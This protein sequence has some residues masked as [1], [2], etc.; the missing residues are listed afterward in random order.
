[1]N[2]NFGICVSSIFFICSFV[3]VI[4]SNSDIALKKEKKFVPSVCQISSRLV[5]GACSHLGQL[6]QLPATKNLFQ[7]TNINKTLIKYLR[8]Q[9]SGQKKYHLQA[10]LRHF[11][12]ELVLLDLWKG[13]ICHQPKISI[14]CDRE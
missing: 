14:F 12:R 2:F 5:Y 7:Y 10:E 3:L 11:W 4:N 6:L 8:N 9:E 13:Y 1:M